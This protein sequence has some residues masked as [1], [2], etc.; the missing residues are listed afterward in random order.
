MWGKFVVFLSI[1]T[2]AIEYNYRT[3]LHKKSTPSNTAV[4][5]FCIQLSLSPSLEFSPLCRRSFVLYILLVFYF[6]IFF[7]LWFFLLQPYYCW[8]TPGLSHSSHTDSVAIYIYIWGFLYVYLPGLV[9]S[10]DFGSWSLEL[11]D[12]FVICDHCLVW[13]VFCDIFFN[14]FSLFGN[15]QYFWGE[16]FL[17]AI[18][19]TILTFYLFFSLQPSASILLF[20]HI[21]EK[22]TQFGLS[23]KQVQELQF[24]FYKKNFKKNFLYSS[25]VLYLLLFFEFSRFFKIFL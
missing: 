17:F 16:N 2:F 6:R 23:I 21:K 20:Q 11:I 25:G 10:E 15:I 18:L 19:L 3:T 7:A 13:S 14:N 4:S 1:F 12:L 24:L 5:T 22:N 8:I 9:L